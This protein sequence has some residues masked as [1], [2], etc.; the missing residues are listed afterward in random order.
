[1]TTNKSVERWN[2]P[3]ETA[4]NCGNVGLQLG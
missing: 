2:A 1:M 4:I 3:Q